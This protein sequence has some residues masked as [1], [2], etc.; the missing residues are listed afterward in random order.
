MNAD[1]THRFIIA[2]L[3]GLLLA[4]EGLASSKAAE[5]APGKL[6]TLTTTREAHTLTGV[7]AARGYPIHLRAVVTYYD[8]YVDAKHGALFL[9]DAS[10]AIFVAV[11]SRPI[12]PIR[13]GSLIDISGI[14]GPG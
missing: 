11:P 8:P 12:L 6:R 13:E 2:V 14:S 7:E 1:Q 9:H 10:G 3:M 4:V 5:P